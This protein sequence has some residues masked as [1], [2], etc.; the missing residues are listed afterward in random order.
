ML[1]YEKHPANLQMLLNGQPFSQ[2]VEDLLKNSGLLPATL[3]E[4]LN[5]T[6]TMPL[7]EVWAV[8]QHYVRLWPI[9]CLRK[10]TS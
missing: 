8:R 9:F 4:T 10:G 7:L 5:I 3:S 1:G 2:E 6:S